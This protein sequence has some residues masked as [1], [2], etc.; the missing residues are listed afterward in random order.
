MTARASR[1]LPGNSGPV[2]SPRF[3]DLS[4]ARRA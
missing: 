3:P 4:T 1:D 2:R